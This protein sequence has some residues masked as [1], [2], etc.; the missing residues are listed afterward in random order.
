MRFAVKTISGYAAVFFREGDPGTQ[1]ELFEGAV[2]RIMPGAFDD[3]LRDRTDVVAL[4]I[5][6]F[7]W[8]LGRTKSGEKHRCLHRNNRIAARQHARER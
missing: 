4:L 1:Y 3:A 5:H 7:D 8:L 6:N 2:E